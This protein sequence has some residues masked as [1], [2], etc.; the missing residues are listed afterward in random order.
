[1][2][3]ISI[4]YCMPPAYAK[5]NNTNEKK[6]KSEQVKSQKETSNQ[7]DSR[8]GESSQLEASKDKI[9]QAEASKEEQDTT[10]SESPQKIEE[11]DNKVIDLQYRTSELK[12]TSDKYMWLIL[13][14]A[15]IGIIGALIGGICYIKL[16]QL[17]EKVDKIEEGLNKKIEHKINEVNQQTHVN[18]NNHQSNYMPNYSV[19]DLVKRI[20][21]IESYLK[22]VSKNQRS[23]QPQTPQPQKVQFEEKYFALPIQGQNGYYFKNLALSSSNASF[24]FVIKNDKA[25]FIPISLVSTLTSNDASE[26]AVEFKGV[27][28]NKATSYECKEAGKAELRGDKWVIIEKAVVILR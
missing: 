22:E 23:T 6:P 19:D 7:V 24:K 25:S 8:K 16:S 11:L 9:E 14:A 1:M 17:K 5:K 20:N 28:P 13:I 18:K 27:N 3:C 2:V 10:N 26:H 15:T 4:C 12:S 21:K